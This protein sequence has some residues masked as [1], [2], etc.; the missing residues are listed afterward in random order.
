MPAGSKALPPGASLASGEAWELFLETGGDPTAPVKTT[1]YEG[2]PESKPLWRYLLESG[3]GGG[4]RE[5]AA[6]LGASIEQWATAH[7]PT[8]KKEKEIEDYWK[9]LGRV[10]GAAEVAFAV[11]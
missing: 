1:S 9:S 3:T 5:L 4:P 2:T 10:Y 6:G 7:V 11:L 8:A